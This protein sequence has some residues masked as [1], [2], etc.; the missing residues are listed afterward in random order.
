MIESA[1]DSAAERSKV[2]D[3]APAD[4]KEHA[5]AGEGD[6]ASAFGDETVNFFAEQSMRIRAA[7]YDAKAG[8]LDGLNALM[9]DFGEESSEAKNALES[10]KA[11]LTLQKRI[12]SK[13]ADATTA[14]Y[15]KYVARAKLGTV[16]G[17]AGH[18][19]TTTMMGDIR[20]ESPQF[21]HLDKRSGVLEI[22]AEPGAHGPK[23]T[24]ARCNGLSEKLV[25]QI[26]L[27]NLRECRV[28]IV[29]R[30]DGTAITI[31]EAG[32]IRSGGLPFRNHHHQKL[33][34]FFESSDNL[35]RDDRTEIEDAHEV[36]EFAEAILARTLGDHGVLKVETDD[37]RGK[38][39]R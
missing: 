12:M 34:S 30:C 35:S 14:E 26:P 10:V 15:M 25:K 2:S 6:R 13:Q 27:M 23:V 31:D 4:S 16:A 5:K 21:R 24:G 7:K 29:I 32:R 11:R 1:V 38:E 39:G 28:P 9:N 19:A 36:N 22:F 8:A 33:G 20:D 37:S 17:P 18:G 3:L